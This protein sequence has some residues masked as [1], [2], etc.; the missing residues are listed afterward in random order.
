MNSCHSQTLEHPADT[1]VCCSE[2]NNSWFL[3]H[4]TNS[5]I[6]NLLNTILHLFNLF[7]YIFKQLHSIFLAHAFQACSVEHSD[8]FNLINLTF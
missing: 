8:P 5:A 7:S 3:L 4:V 2:Q 6:I 1:F